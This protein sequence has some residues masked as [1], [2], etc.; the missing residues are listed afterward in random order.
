[1]VSIHLSPSIGLLSYE[2]STATVLI[3]TRSL[4]VSATYLLLAKPLHDVRKRLPTVH[5]L[6]VLLLCLEEHDVEHCNV[7]DHLVLLELRAEL[8]TQCGRGH[9]E[10]I[11]SA[12]LGGL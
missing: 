12:D 11:E 10:R 6:L 2:L 4:Y 5:C 7:L 3:A 9:V 1:M 8:G